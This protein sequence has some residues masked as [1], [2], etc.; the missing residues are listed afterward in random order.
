M[1]RQ[2]VVATIV[3]ITVG[4]S[5]GQYGCP[6]VFCKEKM[7]DHNG[8]RKGDTRVAPPILTKR[9]ET[10][11]EKKAFPCKGNAGLSAVAPKRRIVGNVDAEKVCHTINVIVRRQRHVQRNLCTCK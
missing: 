4:H 9:C 7:V 2:A 1:V 5:Y 8:L 6:L 10:Q 3:G 11:R